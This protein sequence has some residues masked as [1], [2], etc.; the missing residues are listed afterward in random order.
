MTGGMQPAK[1]AEHWKS[2]RVFF[3][4]PQVLQRDIENGK[5]NKMK[6]CRVFANVFEHF[7]QVLQKDIKNGKYIKIRNC[8]FFLLFYTS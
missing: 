8:N 2:K 6:T 3:L 4:T 7:P 1:R 5:Y